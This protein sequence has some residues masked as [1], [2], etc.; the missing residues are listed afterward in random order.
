MSVFFDRFSTGERRAAPRIA[1]DLSAAI[2]CDDVA[3]PLQGTARDLSMRGLCIATRSPFPYTVAARVLLHAGSAPISVRVRGLWQH[4][5]HGEKVVLTGFGF[6]K[7][8]RAERRK[9]ADLVSTSV[10]RLARILQQTRL[11]ELGF[12]DAMAVAE[13]V[14]IRS[15]R[16]GH[17]V[18]G[19][20]AQ[21]HHA[22]SIFVVAEGL[23][24]LH[25]AGPD[26][27]KVALA[28]VEKGDL[29][30]GIA[31]GSPPPLPE[32]AIAE[33]D[34]RLLEIHARAFDYLQH[35]RPRLAL[36]LAAA[37]FRAACL[38]HC[39]ALLARGACSGLAEPG[40]PQLVERDLGASSV[41]AA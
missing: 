40:A 34:A 7:L 29:F 14:R 13:F 27:R 41:S 4:Y 33:C 18:Y 5:E 9:I 17:V 15:F 20:P 28:L 26:S 22:D 35:H 31:L 16:A 24:S 3:G 30:G 2:Y 1:E 23:V 25:L 32:V 38:R 19:C 21:R 39:A 6:A 8:S 12:P 11:A 37:A 10:Q 36:Q